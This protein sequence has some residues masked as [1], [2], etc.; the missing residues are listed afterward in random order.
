MTELFMSNTPQKSRSGIYLDPELDIQI[1]IKA[2]ANRQSISDFVAEALR[3]Y[4]DNYQIIKGN[5]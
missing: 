4:L 2:A 5:Q 3:H 1:R